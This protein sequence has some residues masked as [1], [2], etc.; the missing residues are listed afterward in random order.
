[1]VSD[2]IGG[3][4]AADLPRFGVPYGASIKT[5]AVSEAERTARLARIATELGLTLASGRA[6][7]GCQALLVEFARARGAAERAAAALRL[8]PSLLPAIPWIAAA[9]TG[10]FTAKSAIRAAPRVISVLRKVG[11]KAAEAGLNIVLKAAAKVGS[12]ALEPNAMSTCIRK[13]VGVVTGPSRLTSLL[14]AIPRCME[15][16]LKR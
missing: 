9:L 12:W 6:T 8:Q 3:V 15:V 5:I 16:A 2:D 1:M 14:E 7:S 13:A 11:P 4:S 10:G